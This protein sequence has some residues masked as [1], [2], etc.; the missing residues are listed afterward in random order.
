MTEHSY[1]KELGFSVAITTICA[2]LVIRSFS[3]A[4]GSSLF[5]RFL[6]LVMTLLSLMLL[7]RTVRSRPDRAEAGETTE[8]RSSLWT[9]C[10][11]PFLIFAFTALYAVAIQVVGYFTSTTLFLVGTMA[12]FGR[13]RLWVM[14]GA[15]VLFLAVIYALFVQFLGLRLPEGLLF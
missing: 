14:G 3:Y 4:P 9:R 7:V 15:S 10:K 1:K 2:L 11:V 5:P 12:F 8:E 13:H 6:T